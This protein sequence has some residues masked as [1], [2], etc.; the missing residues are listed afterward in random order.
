MKA[1]EYCIS[2]LVKSKKVNF[3]SNGGYKLE[4][5]SIPS[6]SEIVK[7]PIVSE[8]TLFWLSKNLMT[9]LKSFNWIISFITFQERSIIYDIFSHNLH[10]H[11]VHNSQKHLK[12]QSEKRLVL[13]LPES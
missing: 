4:M 11:Q 9:F 8:V 12:N 1:I 3:H 13:I 6:H 7:S 5:K 10:H 2:E